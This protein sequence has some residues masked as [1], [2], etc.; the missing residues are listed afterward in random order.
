M[1]HARAAGVRE[2]SGEETAGQVHSVVLRTMGNVA[3]A[4]VS[5]CA[6]TIESGRCEALS[7]ADEHAWQ[8]I[9]RLRTPVLRC[10]DPASARA[11]LSPVEDEAHARSI[12][13][14]ARVTGIMMCRS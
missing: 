8:R 12:R 6:P 9:W 2:A 13:C 1:P 5:W 3:L 11:S 7:H 14:R 10:V 4:A